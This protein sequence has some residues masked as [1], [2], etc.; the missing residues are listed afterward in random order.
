MAG[1]GGTIQF[2]I[3]KRSIE[4]LLSYLRA[5]GITPFA[6][7]FSL[8]LLFLAQLTGQED[9]V[10]GVTS[11]GRMQQELENVLGMFV[12]AL[13]IRCR[14]DPGT[15][16][17]DLL[18]DLHRLLIQARSRQVYDITNIVIELNNGRTP[19]VKSLFNVMFAFQD[20][21]DQWK[22][23]DIS[24]FPLENAGSKFPLTLFVNDWEDCFH[25]RLEY[26][27]ACFTLQDAELLAG[28]FADLLLKACAHMDGT[29]LEIIGAGESQ[30][31]LIGDDVAFNF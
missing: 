23:E 27:S 12:K 21:L 16:F 15:R 22:L 31:D 17:R 28:Q 2:E 6:G 18:R 26:Q 4:P 11:A 7:M 13:P 5:E 30:S 24:V 10:I 19:A 3:A 9:I 20:Y 14:L 1:A 25:F 29:V 8:Y